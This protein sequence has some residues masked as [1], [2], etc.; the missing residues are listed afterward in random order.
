[1]KNNMR[2]ALIDILKGPIYPML[3]AD[4]VEALADYLID[5][6]VTINPA[7]PGPSVG[8][9]MS[10]LCFRNG[11]KHM[12]EKVTALLMEYKT[13]VKSPCHEHIVE[14]IEMVEG[15]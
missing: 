6:G 9:D 15:L 5:R 10:E 13:L 3:D 14:I 12:K 7:V 11:E 4:P 1:M 8:H 2:E